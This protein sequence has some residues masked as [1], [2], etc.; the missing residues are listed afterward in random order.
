[1]VEKQF[2]TER[3]VSE[4][5]GIPVQTLRN[6]RHEGRGF[7]YYKPNGGRSVRYRKDE[8]LEAMEQYRIDPSERR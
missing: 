3:E 6:H 1:M 4:L 5:V 7:P 2:M 8:I